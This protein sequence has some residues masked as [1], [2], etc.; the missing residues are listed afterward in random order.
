ML[1]P[2]LAELA[3]KTNCIKKYVKSIMLGYPPRLKI[4]EKKNVAVHHN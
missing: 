4:V 2:S 1:D 3:R